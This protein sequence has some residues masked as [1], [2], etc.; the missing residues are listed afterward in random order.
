MYFIK[1][2]CQT[3]L[4]N[5]QA[6]TH[7]ATGNDIEWTEI[8]TNT[9]ATTLVYDVST[10]VWDALNAQITTRLHNDSL[11]SPTLRF[12]RGKQYQI[13]LINNLGPESPNNPTAQLYIVSTNRHQPCN[14]PNTNSNVLKDPNTT[15]LHTHGLHIGGLYPGDNVHFSLEPGEQHTYMYNIPCDHSGGTFWY[16]P[17]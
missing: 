13:T 8:S 14:K 15:N 11:P 16:H 9:F 7:Q 10:K 12:E 3:C 17:V 6:V 1:A 5:P 4:A 2:L